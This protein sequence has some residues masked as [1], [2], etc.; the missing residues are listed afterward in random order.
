M[1]APL[2][3]LF[4]PYA[5]VNF[6]GSQL[7]IEEDGVRVNRTPLI[8]DNSSFTFS[9]TQGQRG[10]A[11]VPLCLQRGVVYAA[12][13]GWP[14]FIYEINRSAGTSTCVF[15]GTIEDMEISWQDNK[16]LRIL[17]LNVLSLE[18]MFD[19]VPVPASTYTAQTTGDI[20][21]GIFDAN[22]YPVPVAL[23]TVQDGATIADR[24][25]DGTSSSAANFN[26]L[27]VDAGGNFVWYIDPRDQ[28]AYFHVAGSRFAPVVL[29]SGPTDSTLLFGT[30]RW[31]QSRAD[32]RDRQIIQV[33]GVGTVEVSNTAGEDLQI[34]TRFQVV[35]LAPSTTVGDATAQA[36][37]ILAL[38]SSPTGL[39][40][41]FSFGSDSPGWYPGLTLVVSLT[42]PPSAATLLNSPNTW[43]IQDVQ[44]SWIA[45]MEFVPA[46]YG[47]FRYQVTVVNSVAIPS[48]QQDLGSFVVPSFSPPQL[49]EQPPDWG[50]AGASVSELFARTAGLSD[51]TVGAAVT[52][53]VPV[54]TAVVPTSSP[55]VHYVGD[56]VEIIGV[57]SVAIASDLEVIITSGAN[58]WDF[59]IPLATAVGDP[60]IMDIGGS[61]FN[62]LDII[63]VEVA[64]S[65]GQIVPNGVATFTVTWA[66]TVTT[67]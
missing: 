54:Y 28:R 33:P 26:T 46:P 42:D 10:Q 12:K 32:F 23:G 35:A 57:L 63:S 18:A 43:L 34:G 15:I 20:F 65:D 51:T 13:I 55:I 6:Q 7:V 66:V 11:Q 14:V 47:H 17:N 44:A 58:T 16:D 21:T 24:T 36:E 38:Q 19:A 49:T 60:V 53:L 59:T 61:S 50:G 40:A 48:V 9:L 52:P 30:L 22:T 2:F 62:H 39:P 64:A 5:S 56:G 27:T 3:R 37:A 31:K 67:S 45:G 4:R 41:S 29:T 1:P 25:Y 8:H